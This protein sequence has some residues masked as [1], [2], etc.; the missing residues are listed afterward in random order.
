MRT[1][2]L[3]PREHLRRVRDEILKLP[4]GLSLFRELLEQHDARRVEDLSA[5]R[6]SRVLGG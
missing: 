4:N 6:L 1:V 3:D 5:D 2:P